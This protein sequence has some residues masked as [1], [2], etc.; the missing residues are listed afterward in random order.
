MRTY[1]IALGRD[2]LRDSTAMVCRNTFIGHLGYLA[3]HKTPNHPNGFCRKTATLRDERNRKSS[4]GMG[5]DRE[6]KKGSDR[7]SQWGVGGAAGLQQD[8]ETTR[9]VGKSTKCQKHLDNGG[10]FFFF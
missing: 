7:K 1:S 5:K 9:P 2:F 3:P 4:E 10:R 8:P 6:G